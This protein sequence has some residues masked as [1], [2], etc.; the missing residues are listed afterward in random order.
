MFSGCVLLFI[1]LLMIFAC[2]FGVG[3]RKGDVVRLAVMIETSIHKR[4]WN[5]MEAVYQTRR[6]IHHHFF[7]FHSAST[8]NKGHYDN[9]KSAN[10]QTKKSPNKKDGKQ[11]NGIENNK[12]YFYSAFG[13]ACQSQK[14]FKITK[15]DTSTHSTMEVNFIKIRS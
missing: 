1:S 12:C 15:T 11:W 2:V 13:L 8:I 5:K 14:C 9:N 4:R 7:F 10:K 3:G 6:F